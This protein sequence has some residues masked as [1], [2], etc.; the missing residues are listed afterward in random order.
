MK[1]ITLTLFVL[2]LSNVAKAQNPDPSKGVLDTAA[3]VKTV[4]VS[5]IV[6][7]SKTS[8]ALNNQAELDR[9]FCRS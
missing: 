4:S 1:T 9:I 5:A 6:E 8:G 3:S 2:M 7:W